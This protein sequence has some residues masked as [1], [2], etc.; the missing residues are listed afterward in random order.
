MVEDLLNCGDIPEGFIVDLQNASQL[1]VIF[2]AVW[3]RMP[4]AF[5]DCE[6]FDD[7]VILLN[8]ENEFPTAVAGEV[9][10][11]K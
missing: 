7:N 4:D 6:Y 8:D 1:D 2:F 9:N 10:W 11:R 5:S 3:P